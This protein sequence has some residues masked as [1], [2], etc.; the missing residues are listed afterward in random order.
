MP[1]PARYSFS[2]LLSRRPS[3]LF[4]SMVKHRLG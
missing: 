4:T 1:G 3:Y 2:G